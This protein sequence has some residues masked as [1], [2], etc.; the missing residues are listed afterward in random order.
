MKKG[1]LGRTMLA[2]ALAATLAVPMGTASVAARLSPMMLWQ[3]LRQK[4]LLF[5]LIPRMTSLFAVLTS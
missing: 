3:M 4:P 5:P 1:S 2:C